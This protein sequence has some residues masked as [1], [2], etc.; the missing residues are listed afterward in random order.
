MIPLIQIETLGWSFRKWRVVFKTHTTCDR[1]VQNGLLQ[2]SSTHPP[3]DEQNGEPRFVVE[4]VGEIVK[5]KVCQ[6]G[7]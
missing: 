1:L 2:P 4:I 5:R 3:F 6:N 7:G